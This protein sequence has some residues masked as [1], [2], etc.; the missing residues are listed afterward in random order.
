MSLPNE[1]TRS[2]GLTIM[3]NFG[4]WGGFYITLGSWSDIRVCLGFVAITVLRQ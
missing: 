3:V 2:P 1:D 4:R